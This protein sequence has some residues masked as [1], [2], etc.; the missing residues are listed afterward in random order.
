MN[1]PTRH[2]VSPKE[3]TIEWTGISADVDTGRDTVIFYHVKWEE[4]TNV[5]TTLT[6]WPVTTTMLTKFT[7][8]L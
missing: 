1:S 4:T 8:T 2:S 7:H 6:N 3:I 5:W